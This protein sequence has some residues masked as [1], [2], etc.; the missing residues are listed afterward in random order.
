[1]ATETTTEREVVIAGWDG[2]SRP[3]YRYRDELGLPDYQRQAVEPKVIDLDLEATDQ[4]LELTR[5]EAWRLGAAVPCVICDEVP[6]LG[7]DCAGVHFA[8]ANALVEEGRVHSLTEALAL[9]RRDEA[10]R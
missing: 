8:K 5:L 3:M 7:D 10:A 6:A 4:R 1:M 9:I 2:E